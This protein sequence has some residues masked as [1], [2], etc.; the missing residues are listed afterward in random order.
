MG[1][2]SK[3]KKS[4]IPCKDSK[5]ET[6][7]NYLR[8][9]AES[10]IDLV[11]YLEGDSFKRNEHDKTFC[12]A[13]VLALIQTY[14]K[15]T[16]EEEAGNRKVAGSAE[17][18]IELMLAAYGLLRGFEFKDGSLSARMHDYYDHAHEYNCLIKG[19]WNGPSI[20]KMT[21]DIL[22][23]IAWE[24]ANTL[25]DLKTENGGKLKFLDKVPN[26][27]ELPSPRN[28]NK[29]KPS[30]AT[31]LSK[32][33]GPLLNA[34]GEK[35]GMMPTLFS[36]SLLTLNAM[37]MILT[38]SAVKIAFF[39][40]APPAEPKITVQPSIGSNIPVEGI[41]CTQPLITVYP[42]ITTKLPIEVFPEN[43]VEAYLLCDSSDQDVLRGIDGTDVR[44]RASEQSDPG[45]SS[46]TVVVTVKPLNPASPNVSIEVPV[47]V[48]YT[49]IIPE[50]F[51][52]EWR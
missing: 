34:M 25:H 49:A 1:R 36:A 31:T 37:L 44:V 40:T 19:V 10:V 12:K 30:K 14:C 26:K 18:K 35:A 24:L 20:D 27:L 15:D 51:Y 11:E 22:N 32:L 28:K 9:D 5:I 17:D 46:T 43:A 16:T 45:I 2:P 50:P 38:I 6:F 23:D 3:D 29:I 47:E 4:E 41:R 52:Y 13:Y 7:L 33:F 42:G 8:N 39:S 48:D 21:R